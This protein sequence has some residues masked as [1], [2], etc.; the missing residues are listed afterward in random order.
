MDVNTALRALVEQCKITLGFEVTKKAILK[1]SI[2][3]VVASSNLPQN[4][5]EF[6]KNSNIPLFKYQ[7]SNFELGVA[8]GKPFSI[9]TIGIIEAPDKI[10]KVF[11]P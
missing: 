10:L 7:G 8:C 1:N 6:I 4:K 9:S 2:K 5:L 3:L 11:K